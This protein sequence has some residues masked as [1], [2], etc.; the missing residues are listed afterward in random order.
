MP[1]ENDEAE[2]VKDLKQWGYDPATLDAAVYTKPE[3]G[4]EAKA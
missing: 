2:T 3:N 4:G 1:A